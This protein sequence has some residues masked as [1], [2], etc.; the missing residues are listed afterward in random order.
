MSSLRWPWRP[1]PEAS[2]VIGILRP[3]NAPGLSDIHCGSFAHG[4]DEPTIAAMLLDPMIES[5]GVFPANAV[6]AAPIGFVLSRCVLDEAEILTIAI[7]SRQRGRGLSIPLLQH[8][9]TRL[10]GRQVQTVHLEVEDG[11][12]PAISLYN[13]FGFERTGERKGY[14]RKANGDRA[15]ALLMTL[16]L[17]AWGS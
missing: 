1:V 11:N 15:T 2:V 17:S 14:Y 5:A 6:N 8:H 4:W 3:E 12:S 7:D 10:A 9:L 13:R 16:D